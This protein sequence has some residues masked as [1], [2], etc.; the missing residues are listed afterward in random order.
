[1]EEK[2]SSITGD[3]GDYNNNNSSSSYGDNII[4]RDI[5]QRPAG[6]EEPEASQQ[7]GN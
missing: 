4:L 2:Q 3:G 6:R 5:S 7:K 1:M